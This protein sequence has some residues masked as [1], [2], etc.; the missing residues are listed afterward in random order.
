MASN[1]IKILLSA[2]DQ[3]SQ[4]LK[5]LS[6][7]LDDLGG[8]AR[9][10]LPVL[11][12]LGAAIGVKEIIDTKIA[13]DGY[14][15]ALQ[16]VTGST[17]AAKAELE[18]IWATAEKLGVNVESLASSWVKFLAASKGTVVEG[19]DT[20]KIFEAIANAAARLGLDAS[21]T[22][23]ALLAVQQMM[24]KGRVAAEELR[25]QL[26]ERLPGAFGLMAQAAGVSTAE[27]DKM[28]QSGKVGID[29]LPKFADE[30]NKMYGTGDGAESSLQAME[31]FNNAVTQFKL[32]LADAGVMEVFTNVMKALQETLA[33]Q[34]TVE[35]IRGMGEALSGVASG[36]GPA[37]LVAFEGLIK[38]FQILA[39]GGQTVIAGLSAVGDTIAI[40]AAAAASAAEGDFK[41][42]WDI[43]NDDSYLSDFNRQMDGLVTSVDAFWNSGERAASA[44]KGVGSASKDAATG[45]STLSTANTSAADATDKAAEATKKQAEEAEKASD[46]LSKQ[47]IEVAKLALEMEKIASNERIKK[48]EL[49]VELNVEQIKA[50]VETT[51]AILGSLDNTIT[52]T[53]DLLGSLFGEFNNAKSRFDQNT[54]ESYIRDEYKLREAAV[55]SQMALTEAQIAALMARTDALR[56][57]QGLIKVDMSG[58]EPE[59]E[60]VMWKLLEKVQL[61]VNEEASEFLIGVG[62]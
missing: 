41:K 31:R 61:R 36:S 18:Y 32:Q 10:L 20:R 58:A 15:K 17:K 14:D 30:I 33:D 62:G 6:G 9:Q 5:G 45:V 27:L 2:H 28:L 1:E 51:K 53:G 13:W 60:M 24:S 56:A 44:A 47:Q 42:A 49:Q 25:G 4:T 59:L 55:K 50:E 54:I 16:T 12:S 46:K 52:S 11:G 8:V 7:T 23:G 19:E 3:A 26:G 38:A 22:E 40:I 35:A 48:F 57:G 34:R 21:T 39:I 29:I 43:L 37:A